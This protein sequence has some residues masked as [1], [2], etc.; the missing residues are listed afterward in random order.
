MIYLANVATLEL[1]QELCTGCGMCKVVCPHAVFS[2]DNGKA[3]IGDKDACMECGACSRNCPE[4]AIY[5]QA[6]VGCAQAVINSALGRSDS[7]CCSLEDYE[8]AETQCIPT[9]TC[10]CGP[11]STKEVG[12]GCGDGAGD[13][14]C[15]PKPKRISSVGCC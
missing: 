7:D 14:G 13:C 6:G 10:G 4:E 8:P 15:A 11:V 12:T 3:H 5:V 2:M 9:D 1:D